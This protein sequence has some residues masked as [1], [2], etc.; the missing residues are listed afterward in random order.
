[1]SE[2]AE[3]INIS[4][5]TILKIFMILLIIWFLFA[6]K[7]IVLIFLISVIISSAIDPLADF[8]QKRRIPRGI[9]VLLVYAVLLSILALVIS[10][11]VPPIIQEFQIISKTNVYDTFKDKLGVFRDTLDQ[12]GIGKTIEANIKQ[13]ASTFSGAVFNTTRGVV[14]GFVSIV[15]VLVISFYLTVN[16]NGTKN[17]IKNLTPFKHQAYAM[18]LVNKI[19]RKM[20]SWVLGQLILSLTIFGLT[21]IGLIIL[22]VDFA[23]ALA[24]IAG[25][26]EVVPYI[27]PFM[28]AIPAVFFAFLQNPPLAI[29]IIIL[30]IIIQ[31][32]ENHIIVPVVMSKSV[33]LNPV[34]IIMGMLIGG[35]LSGIVGILIAVP[36]MSGVSVFLTDLWEEKS[37]EADLEKTS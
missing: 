37:R 8:L 12:M 23:L 31:Q 4:T 20:G 3:T 26:L 22:R 7:E 1:M 14:T 2:K 9:S 35:T 34:L 25:L 27:G 29:A 13:I 17:L 11:L 16:E 10:L 30:Y 15:T 36:V 28:A 5:A 21:Y 6:V 18:A 33:G 24:L 19:Q 32:L